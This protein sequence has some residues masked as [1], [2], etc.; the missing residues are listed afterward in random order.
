MKSTL[1]LLACLATLLSG[2]G[3][4]LSD[5]RD[6][7]LEISEIAA[8]PIDPI[9]RAQTIRVTANSPDAPIDVHVYLQEHEEAIERK[10]TLGKPPEN[11]LTS[12]GDAQQIALEATVP[13]NQTVIIRLQP[14]GPHSA[15]VHLEISN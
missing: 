10:I 4:R 15:N 8:I 2:C 9:N 1:M 11:L 13:A 3:P 5:Q 14:S 7:T 12:Q 6:L